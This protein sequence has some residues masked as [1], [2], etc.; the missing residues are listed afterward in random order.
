[1]SFG[2]R[3]KELR[4]LHGMKQQELA[5]SLGVKNTAISNYELGISSPKEEVMFKIFD[6]FNV[7][8]NYMFQD[9]INIKIEEYSIAEKEHLRKYKSL[10]SHGQALVDNILNMEY[11]RCSSSSNTS[12]SN[13]SEPTQKIWLAASSSDD[14]APAI[15]EV[16]KAKVKAA[17]DDHSLKNEEDI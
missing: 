1:M 5:T 17:Q 10:D 6:F 2:S 15:V 4:E 7:T 11:A 9:E 3:L 16:S 14:Q 13:P 12:E 8:P